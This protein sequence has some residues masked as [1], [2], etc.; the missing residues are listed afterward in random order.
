MKYGKPTG[1]LTEL[2]AQREDVLARIEALKSAPRVVQIEASNSLEARLKWI[3]TEI[4]G[5]RVNS[6]LANEKV[7][8][9]AIT[10][11]AGQT[12][13]LI[14]LALMGAMLA[15]SIATPD[16]VSGKT[17]NDFPVMEAK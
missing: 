10:R 4:D 12:A 3:D 16:H 13:T 11:F 7:V 5:M 17:S 1:T 9:T 6:M 15:L 14:L 8:G 2:I